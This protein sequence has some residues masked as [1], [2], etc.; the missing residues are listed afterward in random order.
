[1]L[2]ATLNSVV[3]RENNS[4]ELQPEVAAAQV[5]PLRVLL[6]EDNKVN[7]LVA[8]GLLTK[9]GHILTIVENGRAAVAAVEQGAFDVVLMDVQMPEMD[10]FEATA[11]IRS[12][13]TQGHRLPII[14]MTAHAMK[15]DRERC[16]E[17]GMD[18]YLTKPFRP[19]ALYDALA[20]VVPRGVA[21][22]L[23]G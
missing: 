2:L 9:R 19:E 3:S 14:A 16:L 5:R 18:G 17:K 6:A 15:G 22:E 10:G 1:M 23:A 11:I 4:L 13:E 7:Q 8:K 20:A 21:P 12:K